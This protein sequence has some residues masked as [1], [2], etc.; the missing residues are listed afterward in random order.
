MS[1]M[2]SITVLLGRILLSTFFIWNGVSNLLGLDEA[3]KVVANEQLPYASSLALGASILEVIGGLSLLIGY[4][5]RFG[6]I[7]LLLVMIPTAVI[8][9]DFWAQKGDL[10]H[11]HKMIFFKDLSL[12]GGL[13]YALAVGP[14]KFGF[15]SKCCSTSSCS[16]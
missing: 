12:I 11:V 4:K 7:L 15:D 16:H 1:G 2:C 10:V 6:T 9:H 5:A 13:L 3:I 14:G 8:F